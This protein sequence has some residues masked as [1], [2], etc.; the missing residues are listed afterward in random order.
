MYS[1]Y[2]IR[3]TPH[4]GTILIVCNALIKFCSVI[5]E[6]TNRHYRSYIT[7]IP[8]RPLVGN[9]GS[10]MTSKKVITNGIQVIQHHRFE[11]IKIGSSPTA[12]TIYTQYLSYQGK[13]KYRYTTQPRYIRTGRYLVYR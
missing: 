9:A 11:A 6:Y 10:I 7:C 3:D 8:V 4:T 13:L 1:I 12:G 2:R 5:A